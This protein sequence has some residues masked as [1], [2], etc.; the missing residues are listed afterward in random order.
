MSECSG[1]GLAMGSDFRNVDAL[2]A[3][4]GQSQ[5]AELSWIYIQELARS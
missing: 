3:V 2:Q 4:K 1:L 5:R